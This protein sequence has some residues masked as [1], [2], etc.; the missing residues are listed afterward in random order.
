MGTRTGGMSCYVSVIIPTRDRPEA[1]GACLEAL[2]RQTLGAGEFEVV[3]VDD[4]RSASQKLEVPKPLL[5][6]GQNVKHQVSAKTW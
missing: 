6:A 3:V 2:G 5:T 1:L 4:E